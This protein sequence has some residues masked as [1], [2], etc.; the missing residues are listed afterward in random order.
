MSQAATQVT[1]LTPEEINKIKEFFSVWKADPKSVTNEMRKYCIDRKDVLWTMKKDQN[2]SYEDKLAV[3]EIIEMV[4][5]MLAIP[6]KEEWRPKKGGGKGQ[7]FIATPELRQANC[8]AFISY[9]GKTLWNSL[10][11]F[12]QAQIMAKIWGG[13]RN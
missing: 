10:T 2:S 9:I 3:F 5:Q 11:P 8:N 4:Y 12:E 6:I 13:V 7:T 1:K